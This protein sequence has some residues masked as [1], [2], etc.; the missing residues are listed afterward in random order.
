MIKLILVGLLAFH[1]RGIYAVFF[2]LQVADVVDLW[3]VYN[4]VYA[5][6]GGVPLSLNTVSVLLFGFVILKEWTQRNMQAS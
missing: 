4:T 3:L 2:Y 1:F 6:Y 5:R